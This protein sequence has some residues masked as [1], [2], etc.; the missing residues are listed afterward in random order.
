MPV[1][2]AT[3]PFCVSHMVAGV[4]CLQAHHHV[5]Q[6][7][8]CGHNDTGLQQCPFTPPTLSMLCSHTCASERVCMCM[9]RAQTDAKIV[10]GNSG[11]PLIDSSGAVVAI[12]TLVVQMGSA[13]GAF[14]SCA[15]G[16]S[17]RAHS[18][19]RVPL[20]RWWLPQGGMVCRVPSPVRCCCPST[21]RDEHGH[22]H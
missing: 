15:A 17:F 1:S 10:P 13:F 14:A 9:C 12:A 4:L 8:E 2:G 3:D 16:P 22:A 6:Q 19:F 18:G 11:G 21:H 7:R 5:S 20:V